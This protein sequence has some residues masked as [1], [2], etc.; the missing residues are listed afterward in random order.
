MRLLRH[1]IQTPD[2]TEL[3]SYLR[4]DKASH[5]DDNGFEYKISGGIFDP[6][7]EYDSS[8]PKPKNTSVY[9]DNTHALRREFV[10]WPDYKV[11]SAI[12]SIL[13]VKDM[14]KSFL[15]NLITK[16]AM[17]ELTL[18][19]FM[20]DVLCAEIEFRQNNE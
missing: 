5:K 17:G 4:T 3:V 20:M 16:A 7:I 12:P 10:F 13:K 8:A 15:M 2:G 14:S 1:S 19:K 9:D 11:G 6:K 18:D